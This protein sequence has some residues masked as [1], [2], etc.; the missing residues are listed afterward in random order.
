MPVWAIAA[1]PVIARN[2]FFGFSAERTTPAPPALTGVKPSRAPIHFGVGGADVDLD[3]T[4]A[5]ILEQL[6]DSLHAAGIDFAVADVRQPVIRRMQRSGLLDRI[7][8]DRIFLT[9]DEA[10]RILATPLPE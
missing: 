9:V 3:I 7:G 1:A 8:E 4:S 10:V 6:V 2:R 5:E